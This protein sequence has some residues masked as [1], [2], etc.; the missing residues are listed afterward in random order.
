MTLYHT[1]RLTGTSFPCLPQVFYPGVKHTNKVALGVGLAMGLLALLGLMM[2]CSL[3]WRYER[4]CCGSRRKEWHAA[5]PLRAHA[6]LC[7][8][9]SLAPTIMITA[10]A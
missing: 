1:C 2:C 9:C 8:S 5:G 4:L 7:K 3:S 6:W 10:R